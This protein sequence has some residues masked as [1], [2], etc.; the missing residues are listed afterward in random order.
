MIRALD[1]PAD[2]LRDFLRPNLNNYKIIVVVSTAANSERSIGDWRA[3]RS[4]FHFAS[5]HADHHQRPSLSLPK[6]ASWNANAKELRANHNGRPARGSAS[7]HE[8]APVGRLICAA[9]SFGLFGSCAMNCGAHCERCEQECDS[10]IAQR[11][12]DKQPRIFHLHANWR[13][14]HKVSLWSSQSIW[15]V[16]VMLCTGRVASARR[17]TTPLARR[18]CGIVKSGEALPSSPRVDSLFCCAEFPGFRPTE[19]M[20]HHTGS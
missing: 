9:V 17:R 20:R 14:S 13:A 5:A 7:A 12:H 18:S 4:D 3:A 8:S 15:R 6:P 10:S 19:I 2:F 16:R 1:Q 11:F